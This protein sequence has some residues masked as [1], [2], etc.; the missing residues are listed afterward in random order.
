MM[1]SWDALVETAADRLARRWPSLTTTPAAVLQ[2]HAEIERLRDKL[3][4]T[5]RALC[6]MTD[7]ASEYLGRA[8]A[9]ERER[10]EARAVPPSRLDREALIKRLMS[11]LEVL[12]G[13]GFSPKYEPMKSIIEAIDLVAA[14][15]PAAPAAIVLRRPANRDVAECLAMTGAIAAVVHGFAL[16]GDALA[17]KRAT[18]REGGSRIFSLI[19]CQDYTW[20]PAAPG[21]S[22]EATVG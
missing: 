16:A 18:Q 2:G 5:D 20:H 4:V 11:G 3:A 9:A 19:D 7:S 22:G 10:D 17:W 6:V 12:T 1:E 14:I 21:E 15:P 8:E 13:H